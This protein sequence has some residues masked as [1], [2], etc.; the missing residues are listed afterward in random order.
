MEYRSSRRHFLYR[1]SFVWLLLLVV[2]A[3]AGFHRVGLYK[4]RSFYHPDS[5]TGFFYTEGAFQ[6][7]YARMIAN[8]RQ[9]PR[10]DK[11]AQWPEGINPLKELTLFQEYLHGLTFRV[12]TRLFPKVSFHVYLIYFISFFSL[13]TV[14]F[15]FWGVRTLGAG[16]LSALFCAAL[17]AFT[18]AAYG[19]IRF[20]EL[21]Y[22]AIP[23]MAGSF[24]LVLFALKKSS[25]HLFWSVAA[26]ILLALALASWHFTRFYLLVFT[27]AFWV[28]FLASGGSRKHCQTVGIV[29]GCVV[30][31]GLIVPVL[32]A[33]GLVLSPP[34]ILG[35]LLLAALW[36]E[37]RYG[38]SFR[39]CL[40]LLLAGTAAVVLLIPLGGEA[41]GYGHVWSLFKCKL[42][43]LLVK[44]E[45]PTRLSFAGRFLWNGPFNTM[46]PLFMVYRYSPLLP[47]AAVAG[48]RLFVRVRKSREF[49]GLLILLMALAFF[50]LNIMV[51][52]LAPF[53]AFF[54]SLLLAYLFLNIKKSGPLDGA[55][56]GS[57]KDQAAPSRLP[58]RMLWGLLLGGCLVSQIGL[59]MTGGRLGLTD[60]VADR[61]SEGRFPVINYNS[62]ELK[63]LDWIRQNTAPEAVFLS[64]VEISPS[65]LTYTDRAIVLQ[66]KFETKDIR[67]KF[68]KLFFALFGADEPALY[69]LM[70]RYGVDYYLYHVKNLL[71]S[72][73][74]SKRYLAGLSRVRPQNLIY[75]FHFKPDSLRHFSL[76]YRN[77]N[78]QLYKIVR[79]KKGA[80][81]S[82]FH[83]YYPIY[84]EG[85][86]Y[87][88]EKQSRRFLDDD[89]AEIVRKRS[90]YAIVQIRQA[91]EFLNRGDRKA[92]A[93][94]VRQAVKEGQP[95]G[96]V[97]FKA[98]ECLMDLRNY[99]KAQTMIRRALAYHPGNPR[100]LKLLAR[101]HVAGNEPDKALSVL[102]RLSTQIPDD[103]VIYNNMGF[104]FWR[105]GRS[106]K[107]RENFQQ[108][109]RLDPRY[110]EA[111]HNLR[112]VET[113]QEAPS[114]SPE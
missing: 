46:P 50:F 59:A 26:G 49:T 63:M 57:A 44:P 74:D 18:G 6:Y 28:S 40:Y 64:N 51:R 91:R 86:F 41:A 103:P 58:Y 61:L 12:F 72:D 52:R 68:K 43:H 105:Q 24:V 56:A 19:R 77:R 109:L 89:R 42:A 54:L 80:S 85:L 25:R 62:S 92:A 78:Y 76:V 96:E 4:E 10:Q 21:E 27:I 97:Y 70:K 38:R 55:I 98:A 107:A 75:R 101:S 48:C 15:L 73:P 79:E 45:E 8:N 5:D 82:P 17:Y 104:I 31:A 7:R 9:V 94:A 60:A 106:A 16:P 37:N 1:K 65:I 69:R 66:P 13:L 99:A 3:V 88:S 84:D 102:K 83:P 20:Y 34:V 29:F 23:L 53:G 95:D 114:I 2:L 112:V 30:S 22:T 39:R 110:M 87:G 111:R 67:E 32:R 113:L 14:I 36:L 90:H 100:F 33:G 71:G 108:A 11:M 81:K 47:L 35:G 93:A